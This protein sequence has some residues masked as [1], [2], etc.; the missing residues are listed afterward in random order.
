[1]L[2]LGL[3]RWIGL[4]WISVVSTMQ[5]CFL[6][7]F[8]LKIVTRSTYLKALVLNLREVRWFSFVLLRDERFNRLKERVIFRRIC[9]ID[10]LSPSPI[11]Y[12]ISK[13][14]LPLLTLLRE[15]PHSPRHMREIRAQRS[16]EKDPGA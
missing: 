14:F 13:S 8:R 10:L 4:D 3:W 15:K 6:G 5:G 11:Q 1:M 2:F 9:D 16:K 7:F 12:C